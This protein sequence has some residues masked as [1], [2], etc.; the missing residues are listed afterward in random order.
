MRT[1]FID[2]SYPSYIA[3]QRQGLEDGNLFISAEQVVTTGAGNLSKHVKNAGALNSDA[4]SRPHLESRGR[5]IGV[6]QLPEIDLYDC[7]WRC[8][9]LGEIAESRFAACNCDCRTGVIGASSAVIQNGEE[10]GGAHHGD[11]LRQ[12]YSPLDDHN[13]PARLPDRNRNLRPA[14]PA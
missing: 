14:Q 7:A 11:R 8:G 2:L 1:V 9:F 6:R 3:G 10:A 12:L 5:I 4:V 13:A